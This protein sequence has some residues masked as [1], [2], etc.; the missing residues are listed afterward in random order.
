M[1]NKEFRSLN[2]KMINGLKENSNKQKNEIRKL[3]Q[4]QARKSA[5]KLRNSSEKLRL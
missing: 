1:L 2:L 4:N 5:T 3:I